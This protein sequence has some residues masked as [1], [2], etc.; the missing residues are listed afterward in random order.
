[1]H[2]LLSLEQELQSAKQA[3]KAAKNRLQELIDDDLDVGDPSYDKANR[4]V[5]AAY[6]NRVNLDRLLQSTRKALT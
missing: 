2:D 1:M 4:K 6:R 3:L 5:K